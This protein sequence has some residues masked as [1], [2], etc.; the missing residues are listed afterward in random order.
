MSPKAAPARAKKTAKSAAKAVK[1]PARKAAKKVDGRSA[2]KM[3]NQHKAALA[4]GRDEG[5]VVRAYLEAL[6]SNKPKRG[7]KRTSESV[8]RRLAAVEKQIAGADP[9]RRLKLV[10]ERMDLKAELETMNNK[11]DL[12]ALESD[13]VKAA[14]GYS[15]RKGITYAAWRAI[16]VAPGVLKRAGIS[17]GAG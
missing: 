17:R 9:I 6:D 7:R 3:S 8:S 4:V 5:R 11:I 2:R 12:G 1:K 13:F 16:G 14:K 15:Q 10:Q